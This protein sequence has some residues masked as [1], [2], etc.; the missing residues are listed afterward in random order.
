MV[1]VVVLLVVTYTGL[2]VVSSWCHGDA[3][4]VSSWWHCGSIMVCCR[5]E[6]L[7]T[8]GG[9]RAEVRGAEGGRSCSHLDSTSFAVQS[10]SASSIC[11]QRRPW[12][13]CFR[14]AGC[15]DFSQCSIGMLL[16]AW[17]RHTLPW[18]R[19]SFTTQSMGSS[20]HSLR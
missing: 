3:T 7:T 20:K 11:H 18:G 1:L 6:H 17:C 19:H 2:L 16:P 9:D 4:M 5:V 13:P 14:A 10:S 15:N 12:D 8:I